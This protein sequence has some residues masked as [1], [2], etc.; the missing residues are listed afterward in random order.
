MKGVTGPGSVDGRYWKRTERT[1][2]LASLPEEAV[3][4]TCD[5]DG[6]ASFAQRLKGLLGIL[7][8]G[9]IPAEFLGCHQVIDYRGQFD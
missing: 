6:S 9:E 4:S 2:F 7:H 5:H 8:A 3:L 1:L